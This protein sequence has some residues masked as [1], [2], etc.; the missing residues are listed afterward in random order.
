[1]AVVLGVARSLGD[2]AACQALN[3]PP[4]EVIT[5]KAATGLLDD[6]VI[7]HLNKLMDDA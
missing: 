5:T 7:V 1:M 3:A 2:R 4:H 6:V